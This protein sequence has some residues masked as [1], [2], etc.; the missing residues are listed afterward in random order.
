MINYFYKDIIFLNWKFQVSFS[1][2]WLIF[3]KNLLFCFFA[4]LINNLV[5]KRI[6]IKELKYFKNFIY[7]TLFKYYVLPV[8]IR[9]DL[10]D[11]PHLVSLLASPLALT[12]WPGPRPWLRAPASQSRVCTIEE[13]TR[14]PWLFWVYLGMSL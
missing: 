1:V 6:N 11:P 10:T 9:K 12:S 14:P 13:P 5:S 8:C 3:L 7:L 4:I 2:L